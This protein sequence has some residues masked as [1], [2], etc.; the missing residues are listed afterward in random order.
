MYKSII[1]FFAIFGFIFAQDKNP[2]PERFRESINIF[3]EFDSKNTCPADAVLFVGSSSIR[4][5][6]TAKYF[7]DYAVINRGFGGSHISD[8]NYFIETVV[9]KHDPKVIVF[10]AGDN[11]V[12]AGKD[13]NQVYKNYIDFVSSIKGHLS[14]THI[15][16]I[17][18]KP[19]LAR[20]SM[21][22]TMKKTNLKIKAYSD[23]DDLLHYV[24]LATPMLTN[25]GPP[26]SSLFVNDGLHLN[27]KGYELWTR[28][29]MPVLEAAF[30]EE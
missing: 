27:E 15:I 13:S 28:L 9:L 19:S 6:E 23:E 30:H 16:Y 22:E 2:D 21:W 20:W 26:D 25:E 7:P 5:W 10:Y 24:D 11:D 17:P 18:I 4:L 29:L 1:C 8:V 3:K 12:A 14:K